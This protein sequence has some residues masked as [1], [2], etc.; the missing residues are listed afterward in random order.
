VQSGALDSLGARRSQLAAAIDAAMDYGGKQRADRD[1]GQSSLFGGGVFDP[2]PEE[3]IPALPDLPDWDEA[4]RLAHEKA[5]LGFYVSGHPLEAFRDLLDDFATHTT[6]KLREGVPGTEVAV[7]GLVGE[8]RRRKSKK[9]GKWW[10]ALQLEDMDGQVE[11]LVF[12]KAYEQH[13]PLLANGAALLVNG[14]LEIDEERLTLT[15]DALTPLEELRERRADAVQLRLLAAEL[16][17]E[18][19]GRLRSAV[20]AHRGEVT[21]FLE[22]GRPGDWRLVARAEPSLGVQPSRAFTRAVEA[23]LGPGRVR[24]RPRAAQGEEARVSRR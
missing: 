11:V 10:A 1:A 21:L 13:E 20:E 18:L 9:S 4:T 19:I 8:L 2:H 7:A 6:S 22:V 17:A 3:T 15:A 14:R 24:Y 12:P 5:T 16:D 23:L